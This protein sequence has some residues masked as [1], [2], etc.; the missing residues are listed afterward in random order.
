[1]GLDGGEGR[2][3]AGRTAI[4]QL[5]PDKRPVPCNWSTQE[6]MAGALG[7]GLIWMQEN[8][9]KYQMALYDVLEFSFREKAKD[10][11]T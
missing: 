7:K 6:E 5:V 9:A 11:T 2:I 1:M 8:I 3:K 10:L 4:H